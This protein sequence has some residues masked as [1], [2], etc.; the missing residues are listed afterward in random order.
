[1]QRSQEIS[2]I[3]ATGLTLI[4]G[5]MRS[6]KT[7]ELLRLL[8]RH[9]FAARKVV[10]FRRKGLGRKGLD[11]DEK[12]VAR[13]THAK[14][15]C[16]AVERL[17]LSVI[18]KNEADV[19]GVDE[20]QFMDGLEFFCEYVVK[21]LKKAVIVSMLTSSFEQKPFRPNLSVLFAMG[22]FVI[23]LTAVCEMCGRD[24]ANLNIRTTD[25]TEEE[26]VGDEIYQVVC[27]KCF[28]S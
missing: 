19:Y 10:L 17:D 2:M 16:V 6:G 24:D 12:V 14:M 9:E 3:P 4:I 25:E 7:T 23:S 5:P 18:S 11:S 22:P 8:R 13:D 28:K 27:L 15:K 26:V 20:G 1:M 21:E